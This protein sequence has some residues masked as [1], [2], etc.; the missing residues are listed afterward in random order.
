MDAALP[1][2]DGEKTPLVVNGFRTAPE[3]ERAVMCVLNEIEQ[4]LPVALDIWVAD[5]PG[6]ISAM[7]PVGCGSAGEPCRRS[8]LYNPTFMED[9]HAQT[10][11]GWSGISVLAHEIGHHLGASPIRFEIA[12]AGRELDA[13]EFSGWVLRRLGAG[14][15]DAQAAYQTL[16]ESGGPTHPSRVERL[17]AVAEGWERAA[18]TGDA[19]CYTPPDLGVEWDRV[20]VAPGLQRLAAPMGFSA[21]DALRPSAGF[22]EFCNIRVIVVSNPQNASAAFDAWGP[23]IY[24]DPSVAADWSMSRLFALAHECGHHLRGHTAPQGMWFRNMPATRS[25]ATL[26]QELDADCWAS[27]ALASRGLHYDLMRVMYDFARQGWIRPGTYPSGQERAET[28]RRC[29]GM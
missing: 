28:I 24:M 1:A 6:A 12:N 14:L 26:Q 9:I 11:N 4:S 20:G 29:A 19:D 15:E 3:A 25:W 21:L 18:V 27:D 13:D 10:G 17:A 23:V 22:N 2:W 16:D 5:V 8:L 7:L